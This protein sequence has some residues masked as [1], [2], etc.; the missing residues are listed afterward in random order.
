[1]SH[2][3]PPHERIAEELQRGRESLLT[4]ESFRSLRGALRKTLESI[5]PNLY[6]LNWVPEQGE[7]LYDILVD[8]TQV[9]CAEIPRA[10][11]SGE[12]KCRVLTLA[13]YIHERRG[14][15]K[16]DRRKL[17]V[18]LQLAAAAR[19]NQARKRNV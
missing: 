12:R 5:S 8:G 19:R 10:G 4:D 18:A 11:V 6:V 15:A 7:D 17:E 16:P 13:A 3:L 14:M 1:M 9:A 2:R